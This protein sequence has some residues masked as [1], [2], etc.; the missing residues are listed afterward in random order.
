MDP[1]IFNGTEYML[2][3]IYLSSKGQIIREY[4]R[5]NKPKLEEN[6]F[7]HTT[8]NAGHGKSFT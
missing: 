1:K 6:E 4:I 3:H 2:I 7:L 8:S 5:N